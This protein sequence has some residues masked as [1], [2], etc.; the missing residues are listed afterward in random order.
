LGTDEGEDFL[1]NLLLILAMYFYQFQFWIF[2]VGREIYLDFIKREK[3]TWTK[4][5]GIS[6]RI[7]NGIRYSPVARDP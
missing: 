6:A 7:L 1:R 2:V 4:N 5:G 3:R